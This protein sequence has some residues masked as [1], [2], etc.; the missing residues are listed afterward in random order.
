MTLLVTANAGFA[1]RLRLAGPG[2]WGRPTPCSEWDVHALVNHV[3]GANVR[4]RLLLRGAPTA[5]VEATRSVDHLGDDALAAFVSAADGVVACFG[6]EGAMERITHHV[7]GELTGRELLSMR[8]LDTAVHGWDLARA[9]GADDA[10]DDDV[11]AFLRAYTADHDLDADDA[12][13]CVRTGRRRRCR[14]VRRPRDQLLRRLGRPTSTTTTPP[15]RR[16]DEQDPA[17]PRRD[18]AAHPGGRDGAARRRRRSPFRDVVAH[19][20]RHRVRRRLQP[21]RVGRR[22]VR[23]SSRLAASFSDC[24]SCEWEVVA[25]DVGE[26]FAYLLAIERTTASISGAEPTSYA[27]RSTTI[28]RREGDEWKIVHR[29]ADPI[30]EAAVVLARVGTAQS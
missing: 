5:E 18:D 2:D 21:D 25:A 12:T 7:T 3:V 22:S 9:I 27:L 29:H 15:R 16:T 1:R 30:D 24:R 28:F 17:V 26:D 8:I 23:C 11:V 19:G 4:Y 13:R 20:P 6:E 14:G 10:L